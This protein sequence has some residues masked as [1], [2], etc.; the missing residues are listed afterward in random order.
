M[1]KVRVM[2]FFHWK[3][4]WKNKEKS[5][6]PSHTHTDR[7]H[8]WRKQGKETWRMLYHQFLLSWMDLLCHERMAP[9]CSILRWSLLLLLLVCGRRFPWPIL[10]FLVSFSSEGTTRAENRAKCLKNA[11]D[12]W[13][14][15]TNLP[16]FPPFV[17]LPLLQWRGQEE[18]L[19]QKL[20]IFVNCVVVGLSSISP[21]TTMTPGHELSLF[22]PFFV[23]LIVFSSVVELKSHLIH[24]P[25]CKQ[26]QLPLVMPTD[27]QCSCSPSK[28]HFLLL[29]RYLHLLFFLASFS[30]RSS[31]SAL[32]WKEKNREN[33]T[34]QRRKNRAWRKEFRSSGDADMCVYAVTQGANHKARRL[35]VVHSFF[36]SSFHSFLFLK[37][38]GG[39]TRVCFSSVKYIMERMKSGY[40]Q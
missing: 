22:P 35:C 32:R 10:S 24:W 11:G 9:S 18:L 7:C 12:E 25:T 29:F 40:E 36:V 4:S 39:E 27:L 5:G 23:V 31:N 15:G 3:K 37:S 20:C 1:Q 26:H 14:G 38:R 8:V 16:S 17:L 34:E 30:P 2:F 6:I 33:R 19:P 28:L 13:N 21:H